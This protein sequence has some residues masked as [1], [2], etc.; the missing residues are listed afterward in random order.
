M[1]RLI[2]DIEQEWKCESH[3]MKDFTPMCKA[4]CRSLCSKGPQDTYNLSMGRSD[5]NY[6]YFSDWNLNYKYFTSTEMRRKIFLLSQYMSG[7]RG[8]WIDKL[9]FMWQSKYLSEFLLAAIKTRKFFYIWPEPWWLPF[10]TLRQGVHFSAFKMSIA[11]SFK[12][13]ARCRISLVLE[14]KTLKDTFFVIRSSF[15]D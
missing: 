4:Y 8:R 15:L 3:L 2:S 13:N 1:F 5:L 14:W 10:L 12:I 11:H 9:A 6:E 7:F